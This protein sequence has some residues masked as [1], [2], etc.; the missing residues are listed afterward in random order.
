MLFAGQVPQVPTIWRVA[1]PCSDRKEGKVNILIDLTLFGS[2]GNSL[3]DDDKKSPLTTKLRLKRSKMCTV[4]E[5]GTAKSGPG[6]GPSGGVRREDL[7]PT[8]PPHMVFLGA[9]L[10]AVIVI[11]LLIICA[12]VIHMRS[13]NKFEPIS[14]KTPPPCGPSASA[15]STTTFMQQQQQLQQQH[16]QLQLQQQHHIYEPIPAMALPQYNSIGR[17]G[18]FERN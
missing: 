11:V 1:L 8:T 4:A 3:Q 12:V 17:P 14:A 15:T 6:S 13:R 5:T 2:L 9:L 18:N 10:S 7:T 16:Q